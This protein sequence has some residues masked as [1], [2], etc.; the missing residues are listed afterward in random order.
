[1]ALKEAISVGNAQVE[2]TRKHLVETEEQLRRELEEARKRLQDEKENLE[3]VQ[4]Y[5]TGIEDMVKDTNAK[6]VSKFV[7][8]L[9]ISF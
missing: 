4:V 1:M 7:V 6:A 8:L 5:L 3:A 2:E 9:L